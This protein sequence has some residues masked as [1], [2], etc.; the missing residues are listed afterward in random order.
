MER[1]EG[2]RPESPLILDVTVRPEAESE[3]HEAW[4]WYCVEAAMG[5]AARA[6]ESNPRVEGEIRRVLVRRFPYAL[7]FVVDGEKIA[8]LAIFHLARNPS[9]W[10][11]R[12]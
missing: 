7:F 6:P 5:L 12:D 9:S 10:K 8:V 3:L 2:T 4:L 11:R 1:S